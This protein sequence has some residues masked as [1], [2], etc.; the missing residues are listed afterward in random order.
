[1]ALFI[2]LAALMVVLSEPVCHALADAAIPPSPQNPAEHEHLVEV[3]MGVR[4]YSLGNDD[5]ELPLGTAYQDAI[6]PDALQHLLDVRS[7]FLACEFASALLLIALVILLIV[8]RNRRGA[9]SLSRPLI[10]AGALPLAAALVLGIA[11]AVDFSAFF[12]WM[13]GIF[14]AEGTWT[15]PYD[16]LLIRSLPYNFWL[17]CAVVWAV[18]M[19]LFCVISIVV[20]VVLGR[21]KP[22]K[23][24]PKTQE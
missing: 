23:T 14:F 13:H 15:F 24:T 21:H 10:I 18:C 19:V 7:V 2:P 8:T 12:T 16:S 6:T 1:M 11:V 20:G 17:S 5:A 22:A 9:G 3:A 4:D